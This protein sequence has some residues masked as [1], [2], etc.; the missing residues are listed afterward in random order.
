MDHPSVE[1]KNKPIYLKIFIEW[2]GFLSAQHRLNSAL[3][4]F[5]YI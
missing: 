4:C 3:G 2:L 5:E 1:K